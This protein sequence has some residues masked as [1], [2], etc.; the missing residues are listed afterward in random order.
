MQHLSDTSSTSALG[1]FPSELQTESL[2]S[3]EPIVLT[4][5]G[6][7]CRE[8]LASDL[9]GRRIYIHQ[10][11]LRFL[12]ASDPH[13]CVRLADSL[14]DVRATKLIH[15]QTEMALELG[16]VS[17]EFASAL[18]RLFGWQRLTETFR[19]IVYRP[20]FPKRPAEALP[21][22][23]YEEKITASCSEAGYYTFATGNLAAELM[24]ADHE[25]I[26]DLQRALSADGG[27]ADLTM[28]RGRC[29]AALDPEL[30]VGHVGRQYNAAIRRSSLSDAAIDEIDQAARM[31][32][33]GRLEN[34]VAEM[35]DCSTQGERLLMRDI[36]QCLESSFE[37]LRTL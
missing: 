18:D 33:L 32:C 2:S 6:S 1:S 35:S 4:R 20:V 16:L 24:F 9:D 11:A 15:H 10:Q 31:R 22:L 26:P 28:L 34:A 25:P 7:S 8:T 19:Q 5:A 17:D 23:G 27:P 36:T 3:S 12:A 37:T 21:L 30:G 29:L 13:L 14:A